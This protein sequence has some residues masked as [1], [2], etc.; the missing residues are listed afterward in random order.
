MHNYRVILPHL[1]CALLYMNLLIVY[2][3]LLLNLLFYSMLKSI[4]VILL[5]MGTHYWVHRH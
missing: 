2:N 1:E 4:Y 3:T 5:L